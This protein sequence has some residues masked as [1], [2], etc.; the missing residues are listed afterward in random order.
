VAAQLALGAPPAAVWSYV[1]DPDKF[2][3]YVEGYGGGRVTTANRTGLGAR[4]EWTGRTGPLRITAREE[5]VE[6]CEGRRV[7]YWGRIAATSFRSA[8]EVEPDEEGCSLLRIEID[9]RLPARL[10]GRA[11]DALIVR[12]L[13]RAH[14]ER[15]L[16]R[17]SQ[18]F[19]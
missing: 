19:G 3:A 4:Y 7:A 9:Y 18:T 12:R 10:G 15:S 14:V 1:T 17:L 2:A 16:R 13:V 6:W 8:M 11:L 5:V